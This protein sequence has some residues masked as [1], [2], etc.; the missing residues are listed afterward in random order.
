MNLNKTSK[1]IQRKYNDAKGWTNH[2]KELYFYDQNENLILDS[3]FQ[4]K[5]DEWFLFKVFQYEYDEQGNRISKT[6]I[7]S[8]A[9]EMIL[10]EK[11]S[12]SYND[13]GQRTELVFSMYY[14]DHWVPIEQVY[15]LYN[16]SG[17]LNEEKH[18]KWENE[19][20]AENFVQKLEY[21]DEGDMTRFLQEELIDG[22]WYPT[23]ESIYTYE[24]MMVGVKEIVTTEDYLMVYPNPAASLITIPLDINISGT[25]NLEIYTIDGIKVAD[26]KRFLSAGMNR[27]EIAL[28][29]MS[30]YSLESGAYYFS[31]EAKG[32][33][34][35]GKFIV[36]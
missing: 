8:I 19:E 11:Y 16:E 18:N 12:Y 28:K 5:S 13:D 33:S 15:Y 34:A 6:E 21:D 29:N 22:E 31:I 10:N 7:M 23:K 32:L 26:Y 20:W 2:T 30:G 4:W 27:L 24:M 36:K 9:G 25:A 1:V 17:T 14:A 3:L 35:S